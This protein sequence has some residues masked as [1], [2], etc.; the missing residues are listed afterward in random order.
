ML[1]QLT[2]RAKIM[3][4]SGV[5]SALVTAVMLFLTVIIR[6][7]NVLL[8]EQS[9]AV[10]QRRA[11]H[12]AAAHFSSLRYWLYDLQVSWLNEAETNADTAKAALDQSLAG[13]AKQRPAAEVEA[14][15]GQ[16]E[17]FRGKMLQAVDAYVESNRVLGNSL[18]AESRSLG[19]AIDK[20]FEDWLKQS[21]ERTL[22][23]TKSV[24]A[25]NITLFYVAVGAVVLI[26][27][28]MAAFYFLLLGAI[29]SPISELQ[30]RILDIEAHSDLSKRL[31]VHSQDEIGEMAQALNTMLGKFQNMVTE[32]T[33][34]SEQVTAAAMGTRANME[35]T[36]AGIQGQ[37]RETQQV[38]T[39]ITEMA[40]SVRDVAKGAEQAAN[41]AHS[42]L[43]QA[44]QGQTVV[45]LSV[46]TVSNLAKEVL[47]AEEVIRKLAA[48]SG[49]IGKVLE[50]I[51]G[52]SEQTNLLALNAAIEAARAGEAGRGFAV[53]A[54]EV[55]SLAQR[56]RDSTREIN[57]MIDRLQAGAQEAVEVM[58]QGAK[59]AEE[60]VRQAEGA[61]AALREIIHSVNTINEYN[62]QIASAAEEQHMVTENISN[63]AIQI[64]DAG[65]VTSRAADQTM[66]ACEQLLQLATNLNRLVQQF[67]VE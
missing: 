39:A 7:N 37:Q 9:A 55:R 54:D 38:S 2:I 22:A 14:L 57:D 4:L 45:N 48:Y 20:G 61:G 65:V 8:E 3:L 56:T 44:Q 18:V 43:V 49:E 62:T 6:Q 21:N 10:E 17:Q 53:V 5:V 60:G 25:K 33:V 16:V 50:V 34:S 46:Q 30:Q 63:S 58:S 67:R 52:I 42:A 28:M 32:V 64:R 41:S 66:A 29:S 23:I 15:K 36:N 1:S 40:A 31:L 59:Q 13:L 19:G 12:E 11:V 27:G 51:R 24:T 35:A 26:L 47:H